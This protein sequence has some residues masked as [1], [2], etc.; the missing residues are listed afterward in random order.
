MMQWPTVQIWLVLV[1]ILGWKTCSIDFDSAFVQAALKDPV[2][3]HVPRGFYSPQ[4]SNTCLRL[5]KSLYGLMI[6]PKLWYE[7]LTSAIFDM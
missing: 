3:I 4:N 7:H 6:A 1:M 5:K 2:W